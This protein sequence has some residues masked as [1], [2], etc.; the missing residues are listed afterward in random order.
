MTT[1]QSPYL[2]HPTS[3]RIRDLVRS[4]N[5]V[6]SIHAVEELD[7]DNLTIFALESLLL[8]GRLIERQRDRPTREVKCV[9]SGATLAGAPAEAVVKVG[10]T[11]QLVVITV[12][13]TA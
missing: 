8:T 5:Y 9:G 12:D 7:D 13:L 4:L 11:G 10:P 6:V 3:N 2:P 1:P